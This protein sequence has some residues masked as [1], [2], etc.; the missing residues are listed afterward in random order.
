MA[1]RCAAA[2]TVAR[3]PSR[4]VVWRKC[5]EKA[6]QYR[7]SEQREKG[8]TRESGG[9]VEVFLG[10]ELTMELINVVLE[11]G[12]KVT[13]RDSNAMMWWPEGGVGRRNRLAGTLT[14]HLQSLRLLR[15]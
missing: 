7:T 2:V 3:R 12:G 14:P 6:C 10:G 13:L 9:G 1:G 15:G 8:R 4:S 11:E 5:P